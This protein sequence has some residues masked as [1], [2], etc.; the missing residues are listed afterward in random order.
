MRGSHVRPRALTARLTAAEWPTGVAL[1]NTRSVMLIPPAR[2]ERVVS[3]ICDILGRELTLEL[4]FATL[5]RWC[6]ATSSAL[7]DG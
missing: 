5:Y 2:G 4:S 1:P 7:R 6:E 3:V